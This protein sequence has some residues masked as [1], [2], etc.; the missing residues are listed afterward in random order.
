MLRS[1]GR[2]RGYRANGTDGAL[3]P[4][5]G[6]D[7]SYAEQLYRHYAGIPGWRARDR[8]V[9]ATPTRRP[10]EADPHEKEPIRAADDAVIHDA[11]QG[12]TP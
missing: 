9:L 10:V 3:P 7:G 6:V 11:R 1:L 12:R 2:L 5:D 4:F 8:N